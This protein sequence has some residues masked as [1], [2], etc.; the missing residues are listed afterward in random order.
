MGFKFGFPMCEDVRG[1]SKRETVVEATHP[2][3]RLDVRRVLRPDL[4]RLVSRD[5]PEP[6][7][8]LVEVAERE[9]GGFPGFKIVQSEAGEVRNQDVRGTA[10]DRP[11]SDA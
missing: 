11:T 6:A 9:L 5:E 4:V 8:I 1:G 7:D 2:L 10:Q 3:G